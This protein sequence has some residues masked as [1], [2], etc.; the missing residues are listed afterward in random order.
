MFMM[1]FDLRS[2][3]AD[4]EGV[5][6]RYRTAVKMAAWADDKGCAAIVL[7]E[8][9]AAEDGYLPAPL[10]LAAAVAA[11][12][13]VTPIVIGAAL[14]PLYDPVRLAEEMIVLDHLSRGRVAFT[15]GVGYRP[16]EYELYG[17]PF[18]R[19]G[20][21]ADD[22]LAALLTA[23][24]Q[25]ASGTDERRITPRPF[26]PGRPALAWGGRSQAAARRAGRH[27]LDFFAQADTPGLREAYEAAC[28]E[29]GHEPGFCLLPP[30]DAPT[31]VFVNDDLDAGWKEVGDAL[32]L[33]ASVYAGWNDAAGVERTAGVSRARTVEALRTERGAHR[34]VTVAEAAELS[35][36]H[37]PLQLHPLCGGLDPETGW[38]YLRRAVDEVLPRVRARAQGPS[39]LPGPGDRH[40]ST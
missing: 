28:R 20:R 16:V 2:P 18:E 29:H 31:A 14:L 4:E 15:F 1:R 19:R 17:V 26:T 11:V 22:K 34:V 9:H 12:T 23:L 25:A 27:G 7:S 32:L 40:P 13:S 36:A 38:R 6:A 30:P 33:D 3:G 35:E 8:H 37:G 21:V 24:A 39:P 5:A 10:T